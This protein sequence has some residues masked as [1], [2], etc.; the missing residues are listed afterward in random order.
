MSILVSLLFAP[1]VIGLA[2]YLLGCSV[3]WCFSANSSEYKILAVAMLLSTLATYGVLIA[4]G[5]I[6]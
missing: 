6:K 4:L 3:L 2:Y 1:L 5:V